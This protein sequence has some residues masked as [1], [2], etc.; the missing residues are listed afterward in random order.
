MFFFSGIYHP[1]N[2]LPTLIIW[3]SINKI[4]LSKFFFLVQPLYH[5]DVFIVFVLISLYIVAKLL[6]NLLCRSVAM[7]VSVILSFFSTYFR[8]S[9]LV[10]RSLVSV[11]VFKFAILRKAYRKRILSFLAEPFFLFDISVVYFGRKLFLLKV[12]YV[13]FKDCI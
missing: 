13:I 9:L 4:Q 3:T 2:Q 10:W 11:F 7:H 12:Y 1:I 6:L 5:F 8:L